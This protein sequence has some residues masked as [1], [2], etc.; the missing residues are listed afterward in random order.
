MA[1]QEECIV[2][3]W[4]AQPDCLDAGQWRA[5]ARLLSAAEQSQAAR[6][7]FAADRRAYVLSHGLRRLALAHLLK[8][9]PAGAVA[10]RFGQDAAG[11]PFLL[12]GRLQGA[13]GGKAHAWFFS[14]AHTRQ[15]VVLAACR[16]HPVGIDV[17]P[18][19]HGAPDP[20]LLRRF[21]D[22]PQQGELDWDSPSGFAEGWTALE[23]FVKALGCGLPGLGE[24]VAPVHCAPLTLSN[25][26]R[27][28]LRLSLRA[29]PTG[30]Q[31]ESHRASVPIQGTAICLRRHLRREALV[32]RP[33]APA[34]CAAALAVRQARHAPPPRLDQ[35]R[36][37]TDKALLGRLC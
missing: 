15:G 23:S 19:D 20:S 37:E 31:N 13:P 21:L 8:L 12:Q 25:A 5:L 34:G 22:W 9:P 4:G 32:L 16:D 29:S 10:L 27:S 14:H 2:K 18:F 35:Y 33:V 6:L 36:L 11:R 3:V 28:P 17:E 24:S 30:E 1:V 7:R 26:G